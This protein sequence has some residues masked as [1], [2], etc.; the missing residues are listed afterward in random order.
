MGYLAWTVLA[1]LCVVLVA[2][3]YGW[4]REAAIRKRLEQQYLSQHRLLARAE[5]K[6]VENDINMPNPLT[7]REME[8]LDWASQGLPDKTIAKRMHISL[9]TAKHHIHSALRKLGAQNRTEAVVK[10]KRHGWLVESQQTGD[11]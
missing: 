4:R 7:L 5:A 6:L 11:E 3:W 1:V 8:A 9:F 10:A 2:Q